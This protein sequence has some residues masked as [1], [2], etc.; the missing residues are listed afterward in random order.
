MHEKLSQIFTQQSRLVMVGWLAL[1]VMPFWAPAKLLALAVIAVMCLVYIYVVVFGKKYEID[2][3]PSSVKGF[4]SLKGVMRLFKNPR[5]TLAAWL[6][7][8]V[9]DLTVGLLISLDALQQG[10]SNW[11]VAPVLFFSLMFGPSGLLIYLVIRV[12][13]NP[14][15]MTFLAG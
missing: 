4:F 7:I 15:F 3:R 8:L 13:H 10:I 14:D 9:F 1:L 5:N 6:H 12:M 2:E 11:F